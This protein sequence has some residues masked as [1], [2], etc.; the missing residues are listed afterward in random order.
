MKKLVKP[1]P[2]FLRKGEKAVLLLHSF[3]SN[4]RDVKELGNFL[5]KKG[6]TCY[7]P[8]Y[9]GHG[10]TPEELVSTNPSD[11]WRSVEEGYSFLNRQG[12]SQIAVIG[13]SLGGLLALNVGQTLNVNGI[14]TMSVPYK[15]DVRSLKERLINYAR[16]FKQFEGKDKE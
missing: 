9:E 13:I 11:W 3:T 5:H 15:R 4:P 8:V 16:A 2:F 10:G 14:I 7:A 1:K 6:F 12:Y